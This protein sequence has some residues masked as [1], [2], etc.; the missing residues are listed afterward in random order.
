MIEIVN[1]ETYFQGDESLILKM[2]IFTGTI[3]RHQWI[4]KYHMNKYYLGL[5]HANK[6]QL[7]KI[8]KIKPNLL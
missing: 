2:S 3:S 6:T 8:Q 7:L 4:D 1:V 5:T